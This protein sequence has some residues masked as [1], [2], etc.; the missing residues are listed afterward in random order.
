MA[1]QMEWDLHALIVPTGLCVPL[2][3]EDRARDGRCGQTA[4]GFFL[5]CYRRRL[6]WATA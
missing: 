2:L 4:N 3:C 1:S 6:D 5:Y